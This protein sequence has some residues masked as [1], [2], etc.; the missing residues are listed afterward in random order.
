MAASQASG[1]ARLRGAG[2]SPTMVEVAIC[3]KKQVSRRQAPPT[4]TPTS[5]HREEMK[6]MQSEAHKRDFQ[7]L[8]SATLENVIKGSS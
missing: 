7:K 3:W 2:P 6:E 1:T 4:S 8:I 5:S